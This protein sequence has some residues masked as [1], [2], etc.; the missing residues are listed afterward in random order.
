M[1]RKGAGGIYATEKDLQE[2]HL[3]RWFFQ[4]QPVEW[5]PLV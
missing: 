5:P 4:F 2:L 3:S 1:E